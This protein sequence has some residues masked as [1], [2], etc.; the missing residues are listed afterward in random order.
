MLIYFL[1]HCE[2]TQFTLAV[3]ITHQYSE[4]KN[5]TNFFKQYLKLYSIIHINSKTIK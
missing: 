4:Y 5:K 2:F 3:T 1:I